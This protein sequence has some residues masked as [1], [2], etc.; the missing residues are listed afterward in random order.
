MNPLASHWLRLAV[1]LLILTPVVAYGVS[2][3][4]DVPFSAAMFGAVYIW[5]MV[6]VILALIAIAGLLVR[7]LNWG[8]RAI[9]R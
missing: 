9:R 4:N 5:A 8:I 3:V 2:V 6:C 7:L 1:W